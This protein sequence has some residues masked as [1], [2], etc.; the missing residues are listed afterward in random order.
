M[1]L[2][3]NENYPFV[4]FTFQYE[5]MVIFKKESS[6]GL[7]SLGELLIIISVCILII[8]LFCI[9]VIFLDGQLSIIDYIDCWILF[10]QL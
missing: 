8:A 3:F 10:A 4:N 1:Y 5:K 6:S 9:I 7:S 2:D